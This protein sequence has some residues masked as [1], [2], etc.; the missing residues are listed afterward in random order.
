[1]VSASEVIYQFDSI[2]SALNNW[3]TV[4]DRVM[5]GQS[6]STLS[7]NAEGRG[8]FE[9]E[10]VLNGGGF[11]S[12][13]YA[14]KMDD[15]RK[16]RSL[17]IRIKGDGKRYQLRIQGDRGDYHQYTYTIDTNGLWEVVDIPFSKLQPIFRGKLLDIPRYNGRSIQ[18]VGF[19]I[20]DGQGG[21]F[22]LEIDQIGL[23]Q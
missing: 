10:V 1:M 23:L 11:C 17:R 13:R 9:G 21:Q 6:D 19:L 8:V 20:A 2:I 7:I 22:K 4:N 15:V 14:C 3:R 12:T 5:G 18:E 16:Y